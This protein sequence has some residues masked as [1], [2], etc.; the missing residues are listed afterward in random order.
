MLSA[1]MLRGC[2]MWKNVHLCFLLFCNVTKLALKPILFSR[3]QTRPTNLVCLNYA[4]QPAFKVLW[5]KHHSIW[6][7]LTAVSCS[8]GFMLRFSLSPRAAYL[9]SLPPHLLPTQPP[10]VKVNNCDSGYS[11]SSPTWIPR[12]LLLVGVEEE[13]LFFWRLGDGDTGGRSIDWKDTFAD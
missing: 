2:K 10:S 6:N 4:K 7:H 5:G 13:E 12:P 3:R 1:A 8:S 11:R 9:Q